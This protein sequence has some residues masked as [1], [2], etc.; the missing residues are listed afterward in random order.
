MMNLLLRWSLAGALAGAALLPAQED[1][2]I[3][4]TFGAHAE[5]GAMRIV[6]DRRGASV[7]EIRLLDHW[8]ST[9]AR[10]ARSNEV[11]D[12]YR[13]VGPVQEPSWRLLALAEQKPG[14]LFPDVAPDDALWEY[15]ELPDGARFTLDCK[16]GTTLE[17]VYRKEPGRRDL[18]LEIAARRATQHT[19]EGGDYALLL[20]GVTMPNPTTDHVLGNPALAIGATAGTRSSGVAFVRPAGQPNP[21]TLPD[22]V[23]TGEGGRIQFAGVTNRFFGSFLVPDGDAAA[24]A[25]RITKAEFW[26]VLAN[27]AVPLPEHAPYSVPIAEYWLYLRIPRAG[28]ETRLRYLLYVGP[29]SSAVFDEQPAYA[30][31]QAVM[32]VDLSPICFCDIPGARLMAKFLLWLLRTIEGAVG[33][34]GVAIILMTVLVRGS[35]V[36]LNFRMQKSMR[37]FGEKM[38]RLKPMLDEINR[39]YANDPK[40][41]QLAMVQFQREHKMFPPLGGCLPLLVTIPIFLGLFTALRVAYELRHEPFLG[42]IN[43]L[44]QPDRLFALPFEWLPYF[45][46]LPIIMVAAWV[47]MQAGMP[48]PNDPQ[49]RQVMKIMRWMPVLFGVMLFNYASGLMVYMITSSLWGIGEQKITKRILGPVQPEAGAVPMPTF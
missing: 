29:K 41:K 38:H 13:I 17:R 5:A 4:R 12:Y 39:K 47:Y 8:E 37:A 18:I 26:P 46:L 15:E 44:S 20:S 11:A 48:L 10:Q 27:G 3:V 2:A 25:L 28:N 30:P 21:P 7:R 36:P 16:E 1:T 22:I 35:L 33:S 31:F 23:R 42:W 24:D 6:F 49:Q 34:L 19:R 45:N 9:A 14:N 32:D 43:D 40:Q